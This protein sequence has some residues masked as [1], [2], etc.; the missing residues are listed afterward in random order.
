LHGSI[1]AS[2]SHLTI[3]DA[4]PIRQTRRCM[5]MDTAPFAEQPE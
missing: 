2:E 1:R 5:R 3:A 4:L